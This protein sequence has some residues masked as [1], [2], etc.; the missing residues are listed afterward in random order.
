MLTVAYKEGDLIIL[1]LRGSA[2]C[3]KKNNESIDHLFLHCD[4]SFRLWSNILIGTEWVPPRSNTE[5]LLLG[6]GFSFTKKGK[7]LW[8]VAVTTIL[9]AIWLERNKRTFEEVE[10]TIES[11]WDIIRMWVAI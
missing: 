2:F 9:W 4:F 11:T 3:A 8:K 10:G 7:I 5:L 6:Q 1:R